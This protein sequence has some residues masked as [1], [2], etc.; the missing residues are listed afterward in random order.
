MSNQFK[1]F[2]RLWNA[3]AV[4]FAFAV[5]VFWLLGFS[6]VCRAGDDTD[7]MFVGEDLKVITIA[8]GREEGA[9]TA[10]AVANVV[11]R[12]EILDRGGATLADVLISEPGFQV[13]DSETGYNVYL[14]GI[15]DSVLFLTEAVPSGSK[16]NKNYNSIN[17]YIPLEPVKRIEI[18]RGPG[19]VLWGPDAFAGI[20]NIVPL[21]G[22]DFQGVESGIRSGSSRRGDEAYFFWGQVIEQWDSFLSISG[23]RGGGYSPDRINLLR[24]WGDERADSPVDPDQRCGSETIGNPGFF[25]AQGSA[26]IKDLFKLSFNTS[27]YTRPY[28]RTGTSGAG[29]TWEEEAE[30][31][32]GFIKAE[33]SQKYN[34]TS[35]Y[36]W[37]TYF[38]WLDKQTRIVDLT[39][40]DQDR[41]F[42]GE[43]VH[44][45]SFLNGDGLLTTG[46]SF[47][48][49]EVNG[50]PV[51]D[52]YYPDY[53]TDDNIS[54][55]P[56]VNVY[57]YS[58]A[59]L[60]LF[61]QY[62]QTIGNMDWWFGV[63]GDDQ[64]Q[65]SGSISYNTGLAWSPSDHWIVKLTY[66]NAYRTPVAKQLQEAKADM[67]NI[68]TLSMQVG[69]RPRRNSG[70]DFTAYYSRLEDGYVQDAAIGLSEAIQQDLYGFELSARWTPVKHLELDA[71]VSWNGNSGDDTLFL[72]NDYSYFDF[73][74][75][76]I[77]K[78]YVE[79]YE[80]YDTGTPFGFSAG[81][82]YRLH[83]KY[84]F[85]ARG[86]YVSE[87]KARYLLEETISAYDDYFVID[88][89]V[90]ILDIFKGM[91][92]DLALTNLL[93]K[94]YDQPGEF[95]TVKEEPFS[96]T[97]TIMK[98]W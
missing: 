68:E 55:L 24:F 34:V 29:A 87:R 64:E 76:Q 63:R 23:G 19:S 22:H 36:R 54:F 8:S 46:V 85:R 38:S 47:R 35:G 94:S 11:T 43:L 16:L 75:G 15:S 59:T 66:G 96:I 81:A 65:S 7:L 62:I 90:K 58:L 86:R 14:R 40:D 57:D 91:D 49:E 41:V 50:L 26:G 51:W 3:A 97:I 60:S 95:G 30:S 20:V 39:L 78:H 44:E 18:I 80:P 70:I 37:T 45:K 79:I 67:E 31:F 89:G 72:Y 84:I 6:V 2:S 42:F 28:T 21:T 1:Q 12:D 17:P 5:S 61:G 48:Q 33:G 4:G 56:S 82:V 69:W 9:W 98:K 88:A 53:F 13:Y 25:N 10:P 27:F 83:D 93:D 92:A 71:G 52:S 32:S 77:I 74:T 73:E